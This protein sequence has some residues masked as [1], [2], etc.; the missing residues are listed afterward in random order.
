VLVI[1]SHPVQYT[2]HLLRRLAKNP[3]LDLSVAY[4][5]LRG[6]Q[7]TYD[8][9]FKA[10]VQWDVPL[11]EGYSWQEVPNWGSG[12][13]SFLGLNNPSLWTL[14]RKGEFDAVISYLSYRC[15]SFWISLAACRTSRTPFLLGTDASSLIPRDGAGWKV[16]VKKVF[17]PRL[18]SLADQ[19]LVPSSAGR[20]LMLSLGLPTERITLTPH[21]VDNDWWIARAHS[22]DRN[23]IRSGWSAGDLRH[24]VLR[25][26]SGLEAP[27]GSSQSVRLG[28]SV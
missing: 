5:T 23:D 8:P 26:T 10:I 22:V 27:H 7:P 9:D 11:L 4:C 1:A 21:S 17:W 2:A 14:V 25:Q 3:A 19:I 13:E 6:I 24:F 16:S 20:D 28:Q 15:A 18:F 12:G